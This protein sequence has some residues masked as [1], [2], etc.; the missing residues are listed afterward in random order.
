MFTICKAFKFEAAHRLTGLAEGHPCGR[1]HGH[2]YTV[3]FLLQSAELNGMGFVRDYRDLDQVKGFIDEHLDH[4]NLNEVVP[5]SPTAENLANWLFF[6][7]RPQIPELAAV[8]ISET[9][10]TWSEFRL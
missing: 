3:E 4:R 10:G 1:L 2:S 8:R 5:F 7:F 9:D 6:Q